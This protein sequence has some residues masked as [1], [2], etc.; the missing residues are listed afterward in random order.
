MDS[1]DDIDD[2][3]DWPPTKPLTEA[4][5]YFSAKPVKTPAGVFITVKAAKRHF[6]MGNFRTIHRRLLWKRY[7]DW[8]YI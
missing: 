2:I 7:R 4:D 8:H 1:D 5:I 3:E 6:G